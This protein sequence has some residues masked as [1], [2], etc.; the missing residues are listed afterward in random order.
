MADFSSASSASGYVRVR[1]DRPVSALEFFGSTDKL[2]ALR[3]V[4]PGTDARLYFP[5]FA[6]NGG[7][8]T[9]I[10]IVNG[11]PQPADVILS[12]MS[13]EGRLIS[14]PVSKRL[15][16]GAQMLESVANLFGLPS[17]PLT[18]GYIVA[19]GSHGGLTGFTSFV[20]E[21]ASASSAA[22][23]PADSVPAQSLAFSH[24]AHQV[25]AGAGR[26]YQTG[27]AL[28]NPFGSDVSYAMRVFDGDGRLLAEKSDVLAP[29]EKT[30]RLLSHPAPGAGFFTQSLVMAGGHVEVTSDLGLLGFELFFTEDLSQLASVPAQNP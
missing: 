2:A 22:A 16:A 30:A 18:T 10:G 5:H 12:A 27:I 3:A 1:S 13:S 17:G 7:F 15:A 14:D 6:V 11:G 9:K 29:G 19:K 26:T 24:V 8:S 4:S 21:D 20:F 25:P 28:L 23:V